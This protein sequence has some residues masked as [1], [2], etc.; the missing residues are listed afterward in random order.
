[1]HKYL[2]AG[3]LFLTACSSSRAQDQSFVVC[4]QNLE[5]YGEIPDIQERTKNFRI[6]DLRAKEEALVQRFLAAKC[7][8]IAVQ[9][10]LAKNKKAARTVLEHL[11]WLLSTSSKR[12]FN[13]FVG[14]SNDVHLKQG[15]LIATDKAFVLDTHSY[16]NVPLPKI[17]EGQKQRFFS[18]GPFEIKLRVNGKTIVLVNFHFKSR[19]SRWNSDPSGLGFEPQ[20]MEMAEAL[21]SKILAK[22]LPQVEKDKLILLMMGDR[23]SNYNSAA[24]SILRGE[25][26]LNRFRE[27]GDCQISKEGLPLCSDRR[28]DSPK[29]VSVL[30]NNSALRRVGGT[31][32]YKRNSV[33]LDDIMMPAS[34]LKYAGDKITQYNSGV[35]DLYDKASDHDLVWVKLQIPK[36]K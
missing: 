22:Y 3:L 35:I 11:A 7:D 4:S 24:A 23:N 2:I 25:L 20:R 10:I 9:E 21:K 5:N 15:F 36:D 16:N 8:A 13:A 1:M 14:D 34:S 29:Y 28:I 17:S 32:R 19:S 27:H 12:K 26:S 33:W 6:G 30:L 18:R 31:F